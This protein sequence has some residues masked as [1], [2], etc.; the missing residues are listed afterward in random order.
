[1]LGREQGDW[2]I[3][4]ILSTNTTNMKTL[5]DHRFVSQCTPKLYDYK[6]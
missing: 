3:W 5:G 2:F 1:M 6:I 4:L